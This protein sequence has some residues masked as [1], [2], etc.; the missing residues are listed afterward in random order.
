M[1]FQ[2]HD[3]VSV[4]NFFVVGVRENEIVKMMWICGVVSVVKLALS[5]NSGVYAAQFL[6]PV[7]IDSSEGN[8]APTTGPA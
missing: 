1:N 8:I 6:A 2:I 5:G 7:V 4:F 3:D